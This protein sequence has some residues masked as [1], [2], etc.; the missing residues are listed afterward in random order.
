MKKKKRQNY[1]VEERHHTIEMQNDEC[2]ISDLEVELDSSVFIENCHNP[3]KK[4]K[5]YY[6]VQD[7]PKRSFYEDSMNSYISANNTSERCTK[8]DCAKQLCNLVFKKNSIT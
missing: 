4:K 7:V 3:S 5:Y 1:I 2:I 6:E 8:T